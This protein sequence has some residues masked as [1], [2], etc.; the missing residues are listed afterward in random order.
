[1]SDERNK[2]RSLA[3]RELRR[4]KRL[5]AGECLGDDVAIPR[6]AVPADQSQQVP[7]NSY[8]PPPSFYLDKDFACDEC[9]RVETWTG[10]QQKWYYEVAKGSLYATAIRCRACRRKRT[11]EQQRDGDPNPIKHDGTLMKRIRNVI[12]PWIVEAGFQF[13]GRNRRTA[14]QSAWLDYSRPGLIL[15]CLFEPQRSR[16]LAETMDDN[17]EYRVVVTVGLKDSHSTSTLLERVDDYTSAVR[18]FLLS[19]PEV[20]DSPD[21]SDT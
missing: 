10:Q 16:L 20:T 19:L 2:R 1:M 5:A 13:D 6:D 8:S 15:R 11:E 18:E 17:A 9:G 3:K 21:E 7:N 12:E 4:L 14:S